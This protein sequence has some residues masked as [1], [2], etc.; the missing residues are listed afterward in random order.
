MG[1]SVQIDAFDA[2]L[3]SRSTPKRCQPDECHTSI[4]PP[5]HL[6]QLFGNFSHVPLMHLF[7]ARG[8][9]FRIEI[10]QMFS[11]RT[12]RDEC[13]RKVSGAGRHHRSWFRRGKVPPRTCH[14]GRLCDLAS[15]KFKGGTG[16]REEK[17]QLQLALT[18]LCQ[19]LK[20]ARCTC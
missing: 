18:A 16:A 3:I 20:G 19:R 6:K 1:E 9:D 15:L 7:C 14:H 12:C 8:G 2:F 10:F 17:S 4:Q 13:R 5:C 11:G